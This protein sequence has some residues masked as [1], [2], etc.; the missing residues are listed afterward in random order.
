MARAKLVA[1]GNMT[2]SSQVVSAGFSLAAVL[3]WGI[4]DFTGGYASRRSDAFLVTLLAHSS[5]FVLMVALATA[6]HAVFPPR[7]AQLW[8]I[9]A[10]GLGGS[11]LAVFYHALSLGNMGLIAPVSAVLAAAIPTAYGMTVQGVPGTVA[12]SGFLLAGVGIWL[13]SRPEGGFGRPE[14]LSSAIVAGLGFAG[15]FLCIHRTGSSSVLWSAAFSRIGSFLMVGFILLARR[16]KI[17]LRS[18][19]AILGLLA[20]MLDVSGTALFIRAEQVGRLDAAVVLSSMYPAVT[21]LLA[22]FFLKEEFTRW[23]M[24]GILAALVAVPMIALQ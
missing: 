21:V 12:A 14:G 24:V 2:G 10:G 23:K 11:A 7:S 8:A 17:V 5:G 18:S 19:D 1:S 4:S 15:F 3:C 20:G 13:I 16:A 22:R 6:M 9:A